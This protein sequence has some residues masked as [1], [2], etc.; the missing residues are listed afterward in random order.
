MRS[1][2][3]LILAAF[4]RAEG[5]TSIVRRAVEMEL[6]MARAYA[7]MGAGVSRAEL[8]EQDARAHAESLTASLK[9]LGGTPPAAPPRATAEPRPSAALALRLELMAV[10]AY[11]DALGKLRNPALLHTTAS[12]MA[13]HGQHLVVLR[14]ELGGDPL[15]TAFETGRMA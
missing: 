15:P 6:E 9:R 2:R 3:E 1:R 8:L 13:N 12:I 7:S 5:D 11:H 14:E 10:A 4:A